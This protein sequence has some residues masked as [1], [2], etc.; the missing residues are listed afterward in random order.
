MHYFGTEP[1][2]TT[3]LT[4]RKFET[5]ITDGK[6]NRPE[7]KSRCGDSAHKILVSVT[8]VQPYGLKS[9]WLRAWHIPAVE[10]D[11]KMQGRAEL[12]YEGFERQQNLAT[13]TFP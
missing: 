10:T 8:Q 6:R 13:S 7:L 4:R 12:A 3:C 5:S 2:K 1:Y 9:G 11:G